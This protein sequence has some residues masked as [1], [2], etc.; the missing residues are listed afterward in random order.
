MDVIGLRTKGW[1]VF[2]VLTLAD[3]VPG[4]KVAAL[5]EYFDRNLLGSFL[6]VRKFLL[7]TSSFYK[8]L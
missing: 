6:L 3:Y 8:S 5:I 2:A 1:L 4:C 7:V